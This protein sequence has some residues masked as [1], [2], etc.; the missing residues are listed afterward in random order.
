M[1]SKPLVF[2]NN[3]TE[4]PPPR[5]IRVC[6]VLGS[7]YSLI[8]IPIAKVDQ[9]TSFKEIGTHR[10]LGDNTEGNG[11][12]Y[13]QRGGFIDLAHLRDVADW[14]AYIYSLMLACKE[15]GVTEFHLGKEGGE[16][17]LEFRLPAEID[18][19]D[20]VL[21]AGKIAYDLSIWHEIATGYGITTV[22]FI[23]E[24]YSSFSVEDAYSNL[25]G[26]ILGMK[27]IQSELPYEEA[28]TQIIP[29][30]LD[31]LGVVKTKDETYSALEDVRNIWW[32][33]NAR[34]PSNKVTLVRQ[35]EVYPSIKPFL[36]PDLNDQKKSYVTL[37]VPMNASTGQ[38]LDD[39]YKLKINLIKRLYKK[40]RK[41]ITQADFNKLISALA[42]D[43]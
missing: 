15:Q 2:T 8:G 42:K 5:I 30:T 28:M 40:V 17:I 24:K 35:M 38:S 14:T 22:P 36:V 1:W 6:C 13:T 10:Y 19:E 21:L 27:A 37:H 3:L 39:I 18:R 23:S 29:R 41:N 12:I 25:L 7:H 34:L 4:S 33:R 9:V 26:A 31:S 32:T 16:K 20:E 43:F 11:I